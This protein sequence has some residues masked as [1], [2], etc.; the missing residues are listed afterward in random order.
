LVI[1]TSTLMMMEA[2]TVSETLVYNSTLTWLI[3]QED[4]MTE[5]IL[6]NSHW[7]IQLHK[8]RILTCVSM[9]S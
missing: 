8:R 7:Y 3:A 4:F 5:T 1:L 9:L 2:E 6:L